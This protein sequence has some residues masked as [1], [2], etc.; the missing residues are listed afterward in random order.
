MDVGTISSMITVIVFGAV[1]WL[2][3]QQRR[4]RDRLKATVILLGIAVV[5]IA[6]GRSTIVF[7]IHEFRIMLNWVIV[8]LCVGACLGLFLGNGS[9]RRSGE[10]C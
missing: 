8:S 2:L 4:S 6:V 9:R 1:G 3:A 7:G 10:T 5:G